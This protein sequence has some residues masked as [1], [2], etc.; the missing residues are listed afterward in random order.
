MVNN[1]SGKTSMSPPFGLS[2]PK[3]AEF[4]V[5]YYTQR[6]NIVTEQKPSISVKLK[7]QGYCYGVRHKCQHDFTVNIN[8]YNHYLRYEHKRH[9]RNECKNL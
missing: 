2:V 7:E 1:V 8:K 6:L 3:Y 5:A 9:Q 4:P